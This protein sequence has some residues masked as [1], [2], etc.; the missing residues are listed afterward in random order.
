MIISKVVGNIVSTHK[1]D[2]YHGEK[3]LIVQPIDF[4]GNLYG[5]ETVAMDGAD[6]DAGV[7]DIVLVMVEG[8]SARV[9]ARR[10]GLLPIDTSIAGIV[11]SV[12]SAKGD[13]HQF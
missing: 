9:L 3:L 5:E 1:M 4:D 2:S 7:G 13:M 6:A 10:D 8:G 11:D 12:V